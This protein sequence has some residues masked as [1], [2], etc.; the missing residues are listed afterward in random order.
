[1]V[2]RQLSHLSHGSGH[3]SQSQVAESTHKNWTPQSVQ[4]ECQESSTV[5][6][7]CTTG[8][9]SSSNTWR[10]TTRANS[11]RLQKLY[12][13]SN[14][15]P[16]HGC[17]MSTLRSRQ[18]AR[19]SETPSCSHRSTLQHVRPGLHELV[20]HEIHELLNIR[21]RQRF[22]HQVGWVHARADLRGEPL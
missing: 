20:N 21:F 7:S 10:T 2:L 5:P 4:T 15:L 11:A 1:M 8:Q 12:A 3:A 14:S 16:E 6:V 22:G 17:H 9:H 18:Q 13:S 19:R